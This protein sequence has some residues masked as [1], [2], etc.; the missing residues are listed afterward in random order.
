M[1]PYGDRKGP[2]GPRDSSAAVGQARG[3][4]SHGGA[5]AEGRP[6]REQLD[7]WRRRMSRPDNEVPVAVPVSLLLARTGELAVSVMGMHAYS[8]GVTFELVVRLRQRQRGPGRQDLFNMVEAGAGGPVE[9]GLV[10]SVEYADG[11]R[12]STD[13]GPVWPGRTEPPPELPVLALDSASGGDVTYDASYWL[14]PGPPDGSVAFGCAWPA[15][16]VAET[17]QV[18]E[19]ASFASASAR[20]QVLWE[21]PPLFDEESPDEWAAPTLR[22]WFSSF[23]GRPRRLRVR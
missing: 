14:S 22:G 10:L 6:T 12:A 16:G 2:I 15:L 21:P 7:A 4:R 5:S 1:S 8:T 3:M 19:D 23:L 18:V 11:R 13:G 20:A 9:N 17:R